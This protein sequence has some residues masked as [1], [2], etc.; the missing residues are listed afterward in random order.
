MNQKQIYAAIA[1]HAFLSNGEH[2][3]L[4]NELLRKKVL[5]DNEAKA[6]SE[7]DIVDSCWEFANTMVEREK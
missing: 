3:K 2:E 1:L 7:N 6:K 5:T 4:Y